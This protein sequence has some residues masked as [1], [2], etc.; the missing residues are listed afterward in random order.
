MT[1]PL[2]WFGLPDDADERELKRAY[3]ARLKE[4]RPDV[5]PEA[6]QELR[7]K[8]EAA[9]TWCR[10]RAIP[11]EHPP[12]S[13]PPTPR[14][15]DASPPVGEMASPHVPPAWRA[16]RFDN[17]PPVR[18]AMEPVRFD[19]EGFA[20]A[21]ID[22]AAVSDT[23]AL[24]TW[25]QE[26]PELWSLR[27]KQQA[28]HAVLRR[29]FRD[30]PPIGATS[31]DATLQFFGLDH[32]LAGPDPFQTQQLRTNLDERHTLV[33]RFEPAVEAWNAD[34]AGVNAEVIYRWFCALAREQAGEPAAAA[35]HA[36]PV[37]R[38]WD[39]RLQ[40]APGLLE[41]LVR[42]RPPM[43][44]ALAGVLFDYFRLSELATS[45]GVSLQDLPNQLEVRWL[46]LPENAERLAVRVRDAKKPY[47]DIKKSSRYLR[48]V[49]RPFHWWWVVLTAWIP[50]L[51]T[52]LGLFLWRLSEGVPARLPRTIDPALIRFCVAAASPH[53]VTGPRVLI[54]IIRCAT[55]LVLGALLD[56]VW[57]FLLE[58]PYG[59]QGSASL[60]IS[61]AVITATWAAYLTFVALL[62][63]QRRPEEPAQPRPLLRIAFLP[64]M[65]VIGLLVWFATG[66]TGVTL[67]VLLP[68]ASLAYGRYRARNPLPPANLRTRWAALPDSLF[69][70][71]M[72]GSIHWPPC[73][74]LVALAA[75]GT[76]LWLQRTR[77]L[78]RPGAKPATTPTS[79]T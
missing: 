51:P 64:V 1:S 34:P 17:T 40:L 72:W 5:D 42:E 46:M 28:G 74:A 20:T 29:L 73:M 60:L 15:D 22:T 58:E 69:F 47:G 23:Q 24:L 52:A 50:G 27:I 36:Q 66:H 61:A 67:G 70:M 19:A 35:L 6:F 54:G 75:W 9:Q 38:S 43:S 77:L 63:W 41:L 21:Y 71:G 32:A 30:Q 57:Y 65:C 45:R 68:T 37:L 79:G 12:V 13:A 18:P 53:V 62:L 16:V 56:T 59:E 3:A 7:K 31:F 55:L 4:A 39:V 48:W 44:T 10:Q 33:Q 11:Q 26:R 25:L 2:A 8:Y 49:Q 78:W 14:T 76:D